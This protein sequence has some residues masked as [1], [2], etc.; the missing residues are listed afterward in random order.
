MCRFTLK[1]AGSQ[2]F[3]RRASNSTASLP[4]GCE[5]PSP[6]RPA[7]R[8]K[9]GVNAALPLAHLHFTKDDTYWDAIE[10]AGY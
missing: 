2:S 1:R 9:V 10:R 4:T 6:M 8:D 5:R 3:H 7:R